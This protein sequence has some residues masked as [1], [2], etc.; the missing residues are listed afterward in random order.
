MTKIRVHAFSISVDGY[1]AG[2][3]QSL[4]NPMGVGGM[5]VHDWVFPTRTFQRMFGKDGGTTGIDEDFAHVVSRTSA[6]GLWA[7]TCLGPSA[8]RG[9]TKPGKDGGAKIRH[10]ILQYMC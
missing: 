6:H 1:G 10:T 7:A 5:A 8:D 4:E 2:P 9:P 3:S